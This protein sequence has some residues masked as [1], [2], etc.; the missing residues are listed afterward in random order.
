[1]L[2]RGGD[3][4][5]GGKLLTQLLQ[6]DMDDP[7]ALEAYGEAAL[8]LGQVDDALKIFLRLIVAQSE[9]KDIRRFLARTL[10]SPGG[11]DQLREHLPDQESSSSALAFLATVVK[12]HSGAD[13]AIDIYEQVTRLSPSVASYA[14][15]L[16]H[17]IELNLDY[18][19]ALGALHAFLSANPT[20]SVG[21]L[22]CSEFA[23][24]LPTVEECRGL[25]QTRPLGEP[26]AVAA[27][28][29]P[30]GES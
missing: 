29:P 17:C 12:D 3:R 25:P 18:P 10:K 20:R 22:S 23:A 8:E 21:T 15:N 11:L 4:G 19:K 27:G 16:V 30:D 6:E 26:R 24:A 28:F 1:M 2:F 14:L 5:K 7:A 13:E 9:N